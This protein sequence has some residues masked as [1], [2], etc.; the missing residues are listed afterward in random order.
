MPQ[1]VTLSDFNSIWTQWTDHNVHC[2]SKQHQNRGVSQ[3]FG[4]TREHCKN[5]EG[6]REH[7]PI[8]WEQGNK[9][10]QIRGRKHCKQIYEKGNKL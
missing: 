3:W 8:F 7:E 1:K 9:T 10:L 4:G 6:N 2:H 5:I